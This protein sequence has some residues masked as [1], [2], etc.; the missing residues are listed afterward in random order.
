MKP[1]FQA[2]FAQVEITPRH[3]PARTYWSTVEE[4]ID[5]LFANA[6]VFQ[7]E[8]AS[9][10]I[11]SLDVVIVEAAIVNQIRQRVAQQCPLD[12]ASIMVHAT[13]NHACPAVVERPWS[14][15]DEDYLAWMIDQGVTALVKAY[16]ALAPAETGT[17]RGTE[18]RI[19]F[20]RRFIL[21][22][23]SVIT[24]PSPEIVQQEVRFAESTIDPE[25]AVLSVR[26]M[27]GQQMGVLVNFACH[28]VHHMGSLSAGYPGI[29][30][31]RLQA[32]Y[33]EHFICVFLNGACGNVHHHDH[34]TG[35]AI[36]METTGGLLAED[37]LRIMDGIQYDN[38]PS[39]N[40]KNTKVNLKYREIE[41]LER[42]LDNL[43]HHNV[44]KGLID[45]N[46]YPWSLARLKAMHAESDHEIA[47]IQVIKIGKTVFGA[48]PAEYFCQHALRIKE[49]S[50]KTETF[51]VSLAN[52]WH[53]YIPD[54]QAFK[55]IGGHETT[56]CISSKMEPAAGD[57]MADAML[58][59]IHEMA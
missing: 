40:V 46:W 23:G 6:A 9:V 33:G 10:A 47:E 49:E 5:P 4:T 34:A 57:L 45:R 2:G 41:T 29:L 43:H 14:A 26:D 24:Q 7:S 18:F 42:E 35:E 22:D 48:I 27:R 12:A 39:C 44:F 36:P 25:V 21:R 19:A 20:N 13:H 11:L 54:A 59:L 31:Q 37:V 56:W 52:G 38:P 16:G 53:G 32:V 15:K 3:F 8:E 28:A 50:P 17:G 30:R 55:R 1:F 58:R 51:V